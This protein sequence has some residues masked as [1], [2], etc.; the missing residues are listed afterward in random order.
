MNM[1]ECSGIHKSFGGVTAL[2]GA[3]L[4]LQPGARIGIEGGN[5]S[6]KSTLINIA[7]G[8]IAPECGRVSFNGESLRGMPAWRIARRGVRRTFQNVR[9]QP[10]APLCLQLEPLYRQSAGDAC[11]EKN[12]KRMLEESGVAAYLGRFPAQT[13][14]PVLRKAEVVRALLANPAVL[15]LDEPSAGLDDVE[16]GRFGAFLNRWS[17]PDLA[18]VIVEHRR[19]LMDLSV[20]RVLVLQDGRLT[21]SAHA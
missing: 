20:E 7:T 18:L 9:M 11:D 16:L 12:K 8:F 21:E 6:G 15:F 19:D 13:P 3:D 5:G 2:A 10:S 4:K 14:A 17:P 1:F